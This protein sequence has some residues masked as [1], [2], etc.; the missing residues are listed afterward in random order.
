MPGE[1][2]ERLLPS[3]FPD[4]ARYALRKQQ[5]LRD[6]VAIPRVD[7][8][9]NALIEHIAFNNFRS[10]ERSYWVEGLAVAY[11]GNTWLCV[12]SACSLHTTAFR[13]AAARL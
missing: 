5:P 3:A 11:H 6:N 2:A 10:H 13:C 4:R 8:R 12:H 9:I 7:N 1:F